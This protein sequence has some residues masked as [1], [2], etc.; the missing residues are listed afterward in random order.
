VKYAQTLVHGKFILTAPNA[1]FMLT[2]EPEEGT[3]D[4]VT[5]RETFTL[6][7]TGVDGSRKRLCCTQRYYTCPELR[8]LLMQAGFRAVE[9]FGVT[10]DGF[11]RRIKPSP[12]HFE[13]GVIAEK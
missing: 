4:P 10:R 8:W 9:F 12:D 13:I 11:E 6:E 5:F 1:A 3:F 7:A 2:H